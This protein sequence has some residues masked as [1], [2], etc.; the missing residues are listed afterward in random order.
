MPTDGPSSAQ[1]KHPFRDLFSRFSRPAAE[2]D[3]AAGSIPAAD[4]PV[5]MVDQAEAFKDLRVLDVMTPR[6]DVVALDI[7]TP[8]D[9]IV[10][11]FVESEHSRMPVYRETLDDPIGVVHIKDVMK[12]IAPDPAK[13]RGEGAGP[14][15][16]EPALYRLRRDVLYV[17]A[18]MRAQDLLL[19][20]QA[21]RIHMAMVIDEFGGA[22]GLVT[23]EDLIEAVVGEIEDEHD[24]HAGAGIVQRAGDVF[25][26][27]ARASL[28]DLETA[29]GER[30]LP[31][32][33]ED[34]EVDTAAGLVT[35]LA[36]RVPQRG[37]VILHPLGYE[38]EILDAD[39][40][41]VK[42]LRLRKIEPPPAPGTGK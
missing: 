18:S 38:F 39:P 40:R 8:L 11:T 1:A 16:S 28:E 4:A 15:W 34:E 2:A 12:L 19:K 10:K 7:T 25:E 13:S 5:D 9:E 20:M 23:L 27:E 30:L 41:R 31:E 6:A 33:L 14:N 22:D 3:K 17:P 37:E 29:V 42:R 21:T 26:V 35:T 24:E 32:D 36:G